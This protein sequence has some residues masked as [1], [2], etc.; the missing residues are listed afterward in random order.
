MIKKKGIARKKSQ[1]QSGEVVLKKELSNTDVKMIAEI[2]FY[3]HI[4][5]DIDL[6]KYFSYKYDLDDE[7]TET[8][9]KER[10][11]L[12]DEGTHE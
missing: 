4:T 7:D 2:I 10:Q 8:L 3:D 6:K 5:P 1:T 12:I 9:I 11:R